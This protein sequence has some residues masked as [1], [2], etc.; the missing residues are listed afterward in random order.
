[1]NEEEN[2]FSA[3]VDRW[4]VLYALFLGTL[5]GLDMV[6]DV[7]SS[8]RD[9][10]FC[11]LNTYADFTPEADEDARAFFKDQRTEVFGWALETMLEKCEDAE[12]QKKAARRRCFDLFRIA[13]EIARRTNDMALLNET[14]SR[15]ETVRAPDG[16]MQ[17][18]VRDQSKP[19][20]NR[21][22]PTVP[23]ACDAEFLRRLEAEARI[24]EEDMEA[25][26][27]AVTQK[28]LHPV[29]LPPPPNEIASESEARASSSSPPSS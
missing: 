15:P 22:R 7:Q 4:I 20:S 29:C 25:F 16:L 10:F 3:V 18:L 27:E 28:S 8:E 1:M 23:V 12:D 19:A 13:A 21:S 2:R 6:K 24:A 11:M 9:Y 26:V 14:A 5:E 17:T